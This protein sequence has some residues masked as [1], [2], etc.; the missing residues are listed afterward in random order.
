MKLNSI[1]TTIL[2]LVLYLLAIY[3]LIVFI[4]KIFSGK[5]K[6][7]FSENYRYEA[8]VC[9]PRQKNRDGIWVSTCTG[10]CHYED[11]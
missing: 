6:Q 9:G 7:W 4:R 10:D 11:D 2:F 8:C 3:G 1:T 5:D